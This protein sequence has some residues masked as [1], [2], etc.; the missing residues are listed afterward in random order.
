VTVIGSAFGFRSYA[1]GKELE[2]QLEIARQV[3]S[4]LLPSLTEK[5]VGIQLATEYTP[6]QQV[7]GDFYDVFSRW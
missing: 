4:K 6:A 3:Q 1:H 5:Y 7:G 2:E